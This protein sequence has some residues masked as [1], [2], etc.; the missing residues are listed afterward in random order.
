M[1]QAI[2]GIEEFIAGWAIAV[3]LV[4][5]ALSPL[6]SFVGEWLNGQRGP[7]LEQLSELAPLKLTNEDLLVRYRNLESKL[8]VGD[9]WNDGD[10]VLL[11]RLA[12]E[13]TRRGLKTDGATNA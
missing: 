3:V 1:T 7:V 9:E 10:R 6:G 12:S 2:S 5:I 13:L 8:R 11:S 4:G